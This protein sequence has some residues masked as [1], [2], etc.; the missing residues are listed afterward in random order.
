M[1]ATAV[2]VGWRGEIPGANHWEGI[3]LL[4]LAD[5]MELTGWFS[6]WDSAQNFSR[7]VPL[8]TKKLRSS[9]KMADSLQV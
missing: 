6:D 2:E 3:G 9:K 1:A 5:F 4:E 7:L 8:V